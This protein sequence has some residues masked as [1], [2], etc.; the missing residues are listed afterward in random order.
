MS[1]ASPGVQ[2]FW[3][4]AHWPY[5]LESYVLTPLTQC[6]LSMGSTQHWQR[7]YK[8]FLLQ[9]APQNNLNLTCRTLLLKWPQMLQLLKGLVSFHTVA[10]SATQSHQ[11]NL[12]VSL[13][14]TEIASASVGMACA[15]LSQEGSSL[16]LEILKQPKRAEKSASDWSGLLGVALGLAS[17]PQFLDQNLDIFRHQLLPPDFAWEKEMGPPWPCSSPQFHLR[18]EDLPQKILPKPNNTKF[19]GNAAAY[20]LGSLWHFSWQQWQI[21]NAMVWDGRMVFLS[22]SSSADASRKALHVPGSLP[23][24]ILY[25]NRQL[26]V[27]VAKENHLS[28]C[29]LSESRHHQSW[30]HPEAKIIQHPKFRFPNNRGRKIVDNSWLMLFV[31]RVLYHDCFSANGPSAVDGP[32]PTLR[33]FFEVSRNLHGKPWG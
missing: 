33:P 15:R 7:N 8:D 22:G 21:I 11:L 26:A 6:P 9:D 1:L 20:L 27:L 13:C 14:G 19:V 4:G 17:A 18:N 23:P 24:L 25:A 10:Y 2:H 28:W 29:R 16:L 31:H 5:L 32:A 3:A 12:P 30:R